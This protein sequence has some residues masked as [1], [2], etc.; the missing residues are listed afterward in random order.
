M[1]V[2]EEIIVSL[3]TWSAR[4]K[5]IPVVL[6]SIYNQ[7]IKPNKVVLNLSVGEIVPSELEHYITE[8]QIEVNYVPDTK[9][10]KKLL[11][12]LLRYPTACVINIDDDC[13]YPKGM[14]E[15]FVSLHRKYP[16]FP[17]SGNKVI[18]FGMQCHCGCASLTKYEYFGE[19]LND[20][21]EDLMASCPSDDMVF[22][23]LA[24]FNCH[25][26]IRTDNLYSD[27]LVAE[28]LEIQS[29]TQLVVLPQDGINRTYNYLIHRFGTLP[30][31]VGT[32][33]KDSHFSS[34]INDI[35][36]DKIQCVEIE[37]LQ[38]IENKFRSTYAYRLGKF[39]LRPLSWL[40]NIVNKE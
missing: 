24:T 5:N 28:S 8:H 39:L 33:V 15:E 23:Y 4:I 6:D 18:Y 3:T 27:N 30:F 17:I 16:Q 2:N 13:I 35:V 11:P 29:Y 14:I 1:S 25:P 12:T 31:L 10:Y 38:T 7:T 9:V 19:R 32:Y 21:D 34:L 40:R 36:T 37:S 26:Y 22:T 20:I